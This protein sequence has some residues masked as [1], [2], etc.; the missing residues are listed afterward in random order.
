LNIKGE[1]KMN[2]VQPIREM[3]QIEKMKSFLMERSYRDWFLFVMG[4]NTG[5]RIS[6][7][8]QLKVKAGYMMVN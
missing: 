8:L 6:D 3:E 7:L 5:L 2:E 4:I 1:K